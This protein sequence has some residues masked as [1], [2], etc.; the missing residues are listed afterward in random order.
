M[1]MHSG[2]YAAAGGALLTMTL[3]RSVAIPLCSPFIVL[4][5]VADEWPGQQTCP[6]TPLPAAAMTHTWAMSGSMHTCLSHIQ[7]H[8]SSSCSTTDCKCICQTSSTRSML[9]STS[10]CPVGGCIQRMPHPT[11][12]LSPSS[13]SSIPHGTPTAG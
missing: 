2:I 11:T 4:C 1:N 9:T 7:T 8:H 12:P 10:W 6:T 5:E 13:C 3:W